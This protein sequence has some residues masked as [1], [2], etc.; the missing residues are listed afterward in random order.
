MQKD[1]RVFLL[2]LF[3]F[4]IASV[5]SIKAQYVYGSSALGYDNNNKEVF[6]YSRT[7]VDAYVGL[8]YDPYV[9]GKLYR[10]N[11]QV[12]S[13][14][15]LGW[16]QY[17]TARV[18]L[19]TP[20]SPETQFTIISEHW[21]KRATYTDV[22]ILGYTQRY[23]WDPWGF[24]NFSPG[25]RSSF[26]GW[27]YNRY[28]APQ[29]TYLGY[30]GVSGI[31]PPD[32]VCKPDLLA[33]E[34]GVLIMGS[35]GGT[36][37]APT[38]GCPTP[39]PTP[40]VNANVMSVGFAGNFEMYQYD[41]PQAG[42][43]S[44]P[45]WTQG[46]SNNINHPVAYQMGTETSK[47]KLSANI[48]LSP[49][50]PSGQSISAK[51]R[52]KKGSQQ[53]ITAETPVTLTGSSIDV[54][55]IQ[56][57][58][59]LE[60][61]PKV[62]KSNY[63]FAWEI[64]FDGG[65]SWRS[66]GNS[67][68]HPVYWTYGDPTA[69]TLQPLFKN[70]YGDSF[71]ILYDKALE[72]VTN[73]LGEGETDVEKIVTKVNKGIDAD[74]IYNPG[75][76]ASNT[77]HPLDAYTRPTG[78]QCSGNANLLRGLLRSV[79]INAETYYYYGGNNTTGVKKAYFYKWRYDPSLP[80]GDVSFKVL[81][82]A[83]KDSPATDLPSNPHFT[84]HAMVIVNGI[85][86]KRFDPS[87]GLIET[88]GKKVDETLDWQS[89][90]ANPSVEK[91]LFGSA[92]ANSV[93]ERPSPVTVSEAIGTL[94]TCKHIGNANLPARAMNSFDSD[95]VTDYAVWR[96]S[97]GVWYINN[98]SDDSF[99]ASQ[100]GSSGDIITPGDYDGDGRIDPALY[101]PSN[102]TWYILESTTGN[103]HSVAFGLNSDKPVSGDYD[104]DGK[105]DV[106]VYRPSTGNWYVQKSR[107]GFYAIQFGVSTDKPVPADYDGDGQIDVAVYRPSN[108]VWY[109][110]ES[111]T[112]TVRSLQWGDIGVDAIPVPGD[113]D[114]DGKSDVAVWNSANGNWS[115]LSSSG[116]N[117]YDNFGNKS[118][119]DI[120][121]PGDY[122]GDGK[123]DIAVWRPSEANWY[124][125]RSSDWTLQTKQWGTT[126]DVP[127]P[128]SIN[129]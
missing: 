103:W 110:V 70:S 9:N 15:N 93:V 29:W 83:K 61:T 82:P 12:A 45:T 55:G 5:S 8:D 47:M 119:G 35:Q 22:I 112:N 105:T 87:Y 41:A 98:S 129:R 14:A 57:T 84:F 114:G 75:E 94:A 109:I 54:S 38:A 49:A 73:K 63:N 118:L 92:T 40:T 43:I 89:Y 125:R 50:V 64:S 2:I 11:Q 36:G 30:T 74:L 16:A 107:D 68:S 21:V 116:S 32:D 23:W 91:F 48:S 28:V 80:P 100:F 33:P 18:N 81:R 79:G 85:A 69:Q 78:T 24:S 44:N 27:G 10:V 115:I 1:L 60:T 4:F 31:T 71:M 104:G 56:V 97:E 90:I 52:V 13:Q 86:N 99:V 123:A 19:Y 121:I 72:Q 122:D 58:T 39:T 62:K 51:I 111:S 34:D 124:I 53:V 65:A 37:N 3:V 25:Y 117:I 95:T 17:T 66:M 106:A 26:P 6:S 102:A 113:Y 20:S 108:G 59:A 7:W 88:G 46:G 128:F 120:P 96:P 42:L 77:T 67:G 126:Q 76:S 127:V 101:R